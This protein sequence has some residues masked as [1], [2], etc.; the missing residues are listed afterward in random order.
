MGLRKTSLDSQRIE[1]RGDSEGSWHRIQTRGHVTPK[2]RG[3]DAPVPCYCTWAR[4]TSQ[5]PQDLVPCHITGEESEAQNDSHR[6]TFTEQLVGMLTA[7]LVWVAMEGE[8]RFLLP[9]TMLSDQPAYPLE[10]STACFY[11]HVSTMDSH[12]KP[13][14]WRYMHMWLFCCCH[15]GELRC[16]ELRL[17]AMLDL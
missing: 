12:P 6:G 5:K 3:E 13:E 8:L 11:R 16:T 1:Y 4:D 10:A 7:S 14:V 2:Q 15:Y 17:F 9:G